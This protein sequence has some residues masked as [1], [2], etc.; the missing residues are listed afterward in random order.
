[1]RGEN[2]GR[3]HYRALRLLFEADDILR[4]LRQKAHGLRG[5]FRDPQLKLEM[6]VHHL[7]RYPETLTESM[8]QRGHM[9]HRLKDT[10]QRGRCGTI[11]SRCFVHTTNHAIRMP[12]KRGDF[13]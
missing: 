11:S 4:E 7:N 9:L 12:E 6:I 5:I 13:F 3:A 1:M 10:L 8:H 2:E